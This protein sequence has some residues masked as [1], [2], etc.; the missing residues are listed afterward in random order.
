MQNLILRF[1]NK[2]FKKIKLIAVMQKRR[3][4]KIEFFNRLFN[5]KKT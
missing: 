5:C 4:V 2:T 1:K 3:H